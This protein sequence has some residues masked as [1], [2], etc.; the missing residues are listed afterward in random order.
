[1]DDMYVVDR[2][3]TIT[4]Q[5]YSLSSRTMNV[6]AVA[7]LRN[8]RDASAVAR[9]V[10]DSTEHT[11]LAGDQATAFAERMGF[12]RE[13]LVTADSANIWKKWQEKGCQPNFWSTDVEPNPRTHC[14]P[15]AAPLTNE[16][17][18]MN[19]SSRRRQE[20]GRRHHDTIGMIVIDGDGHVAAGTST[21]G[22]RYKIPG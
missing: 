18:G 20:F 6:G 11:L 13:S 9:H 8:I 4:K 3:T 10:L 14:G 7:A 17:A 12:R 22:A 21:N 16:V 5:P 15:Y 2:L 19:N 1:M